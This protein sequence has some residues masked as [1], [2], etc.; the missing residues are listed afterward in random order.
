MR[1][2]I[3]TL[4]GQVLGQR[5]SKKEAIALALQQAHQL[6]ESIEVQKRNSDGEYEMLTIVL[7]PEKFS[8][9]DEDD[10]ITWQRK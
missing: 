3:L 8:T 6:R 5:M 1:Y 9:L 4:D 7:N 10:D 2:R